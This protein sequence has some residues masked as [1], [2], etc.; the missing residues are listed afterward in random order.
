MIAY[1]AVL[2]IAAVS[3]NEEMQLRGAPGTAIGAIASKLPAGFSIGDADAD[4][5]G[6]VTWK[7]LYDAL[8]KFKIPNLDTGVVK[9]LIKKFATDGPAE[10]A[11]GGLDSAE[12]SK[13]IAYFKKKSADALIPKN[14]SKADKGCYIKVHPI[15]DDEDYGKTYRGLVTTTVSGRSCQNWL[16]KKPH[17][18]GIKATAK[19]GLGN[20]NFCRNPDKSFKKPWCF[21]MDPSTEKEECEIPLCEGMSRD[22]QEESEKLAMKVAEGLECD[23]MAQLYGSSTT[24]ADTTVLMQ[25][26]KKFGKANLEAA[27]KRCKCNKG[28]IAVLKRR[29]L[30]EEILGTN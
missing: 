4:G 16:D 5:N 20:H 10:G 9:G 22:F 19:N 13:M 12:F 29:Q 23:C 11:G 25:L 18:T 1:F 2:F 28:A 27:A 21:T 26:E 30:K 14:P 3:G 8:N 6:S 17:D 24:T 15:T 7:E